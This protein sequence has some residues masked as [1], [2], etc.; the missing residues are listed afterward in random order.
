MQ[1][2]KQQQL[3]LLRQEK[4]V[5]I[6]RSNHSEQLVRV[7]EALSAG[8]ISILEITFT[9]PGALKIIEAVAD[10][11]GDRVLVGAGTVLDSETARSAMLAGAEFFVSPGTSIDV[12]QT[13]RRYDKAV[14]PG[15][16]TP[17]EV[18]TAWEAGC[19]AVKVFPCD[20]V[21]ARHIKALRGPLPQIPLIPTGG[22][23]IDTVNDFMDAGA[24]AV[25][26][27]SSLAPQEAIAQGD[28]DTVAECARKF[29]A[30]LNKWD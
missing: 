16:F 3:D 4:I 19:D 22:V 29:V 14:F 2:N 18:L 27:G 26:V 9:V 12:I 21:G 24:M 25:G 13:C 23:N 5:A 8:G 11:I 10:R 6:L 28:F 17:T 15:A 7:A 20:V 30:R 1:L